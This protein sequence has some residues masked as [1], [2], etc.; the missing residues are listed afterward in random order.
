MA[1]HSLTLQYEES[2]TKIDFAGR[3]AESRDELK[4]LTSYWT[5]INGKWKFR[6]VAVLAAAAD[7]G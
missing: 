5:K 7:L 2:R 6:A 4:E 1:Q 3:A